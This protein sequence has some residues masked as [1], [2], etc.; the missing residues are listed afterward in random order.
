MGPSA[1]LSPPWMSSNAAKGTPKTATLTAAPVD[2]PTLM[3]R[4]AHRASI[5]ERGSLHS[6]S[7]SAPKMVVVMPSAMQSD[8]MCK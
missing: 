1:L 8:A 4:R 6:Y 7:M 5:S 2:S 3:W